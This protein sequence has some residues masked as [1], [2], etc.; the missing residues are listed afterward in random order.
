MRV[1]WFADAQLPEITGAPTTGGGWVEGLRRALEGFAPEVELGIASPGGVVHDPF[2]AGNA[3]YFHVAH[4]AAGGRV[5]GVRHRW[6]HN[7]VPD[8][9][10]AGCVAIAHAYAPDIVHIHGAEH[11]FGLA[12]THLDAPVVVSLQGIA[13][14]YQRFSLTG[15]R[16]PDVLREVPTRTFVR[17]YGPL[18]A[19][20]TL[21]ARAAVERRIL[22]SCDDF[23]GRTEW[24]RSVL[25]MLVPGARYH[26]VGEVLGE[27]FYE[28]Q[29]LGLR[30]G[31]ETLYCTGGASALKGVELLLEALIML[32]RSGVR[33]PRLRL[34]G[35][36]T[37]GLLARKITALLG[38]PELRGA[39]DVLGRCTPA[40][41]AGELASASA[42]VLPSHMDNSP[43]AL[44]EAMLVGTPCIAAFV[45]GVPSLVKDGVEGL[46]YHD[47]DP[48]ALAG[49]IDQ[50]LG[51]PALAVR[52]GANARETA[53]RRHDP[54]TV[55]KQAVDTYREVLARWRER[56]PDMGRPERRG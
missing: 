6:R 7:P 27:P 3:T 22:A 15:L 21:Q 45:G 8:G 20:W 41:I 25:R 52:L 46:L 4:P 37:D 55:A 28:K 32:R 5:A 26:E 35:G 11:Y 51:D 23:M 30:A 1:L 12:T 9:A 53:R 18:H 13:T 39:V 14:V 34:A 31:E 49:K 56:R 50:L 42:F 38:A 47:S 36:V 10:V 17:G 43:N 2:S 16:W 33:S 40:Q 54:Q 19:S 44:C 24:D 48:F 29:W